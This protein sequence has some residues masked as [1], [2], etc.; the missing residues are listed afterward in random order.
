MKTKATGTIVPSDDELLASVRRR[1]AGVEPLI[2]SPGAWSA[3]TAGAGAPVRS[4]V[5]SRVGFVGLAP[6]VLVA[7]L[8][9]V[10]V[11]YGLGSKTWGGAGSDDNMTTLTYKLEA[12]NGQPPV[13]TGLE[14]T[15]RILR[16]RLTSAG[17]PNFSVTSG[18]FDTVVVKVPAGV[19]L[20]GV[21]KVIGQTGHIEFILLPR[22]DYGTA[23]TAGTKPVPA[24]GA[25]IDPGLQAQFTGAD[26]DPAKTAAVSDTINSGFWKIVF[27]FSNTK[28]SE[29]EAWSGAHVNEYF[30]IVLD[31]KVL[32]APYIKSAIAGGSGE[33]S[34]SYTEAGANDLAAVL[35]GGSLPYPL[36][37]E[38]VLGPG[39]TATPSSSPSLPQIVAPSAQ[40]STDIPS[41]GRTLGNADAPVTLDFWGDYQC[42]VCGS[43]AT[44]TE[45]QLIVN[46]VRTG[47]LKI[48]YHDFIVID[49]NNG[50]H[51]SENAADAARIAAD[52]GK[53]WIFSD[54]LWANQQNELAGEFSRDRLIEIAR[55]SGLDV[56]AFTADLDAGK[57]L[58]EVRAESAAG[59]TAGYIGVPTILINGQQNYPGTALLR[60]DT[61]S[62]AI[63]QAL[64]APST[65]AA[66]SPPSTSA[67]PSTVASA[68]PSPTPAATV[69]GPAQIASPRP[70]L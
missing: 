2:P 11:G 63:D 48:A 32:S 64:A 57:H 51:D 47:K 37:L 42:T 19:D 17:V 23:D 21:E 8:V 45:R 4:V 40:T 15:V 24:V 59:Q 28:A 68:G 39:E 34:G 9:V 18:A 65:S 1:I 66:P 61:I 5:R 52:Q 69:A 55:L 14:V 12:V 46:Y 16:D 54:F 3:A 26:L 29:L 36:V 35:E 38:S 70:S 20:S 56:A 67:A 30:A 62:A 41:S 7:A 50:G 58:A 22:A 25:T 13:S 27:G 31:G 60:Y 10:A 49:N 6:L 44:D 33:I 43:F 53:F